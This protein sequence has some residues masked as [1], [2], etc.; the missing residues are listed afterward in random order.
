MNADQRRLFQLLTVGNCIFDNLLDICQ[1][2]TIAI[3]AVV[4]Q[5]FYEDIFG[6]T[7][8][9]NEIQRVPSVL[10]HSVDSSRES[11]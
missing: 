8:T 1:D 3:A 4:L 7:A 9:L 11:M 6:K 2:L 10:S 5:P